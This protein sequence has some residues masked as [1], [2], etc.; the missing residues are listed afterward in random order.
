M[1]PNLDPLT[2]WLLGEIRAAGEDGEF[3]FRD[4]LFVGSFLSEERK[5]GV[6]DWNSGG[7]WGEE[8]E[9]YISAV[10]E[11][12]ACLLRTWCDDHVRVFTTLS[13]LASI[14]GDWEERLIMERHHY[15][16]ALQQTRR[17]CQVHAD[18]AQYREQEPDLERGER[19]SRD[20]QGLDLDA[21]TLREGDLSIEV[22]GYDGQGEGFGGGKWR[23][24]RGR[25][26]CGWYFEGGIRG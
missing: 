23:A 24:R 26:A 2:D 14:A 17:A 8:C 10:W 18:R 9:V 6:K 7:S 19:G 20:C 22:A 25:Y 16:G 15:R 11:F 3:N 1:S 4:S 13:F 5:K 12:S 21:E